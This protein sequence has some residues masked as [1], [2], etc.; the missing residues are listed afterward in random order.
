[1]LLKQL[2][3]TTIS[4]SLLSSSA[5]SFAKS[6][7]QP[8]IVDYTTRHHPVIA[9]D[10]MVSSQN[11]L[12]TEIGAQILRDGGNAIDASVAVG[13][14]LA[15]TL[16]RAGNLGGGGFMLVHIAE[17][18]KTIALDYRE[19][20]P[21]AAHPDMFFELDKNGN[22]VK[23]SRQDYHFNHRSSAV[24]GTVAGFE[25]VLKKYGTMSW[26]QV[27]APAIKLAREG[28]VVTDDL[29]SILR[30]KHKVL[31]QHPS[32]KKIFIKPDGSGY[33]AGD[34]L[35]QKDLAWSLQQLAK[36]GAKAFYQGEIG[37][38][39][40]ADMAANNGLITMEDLANYQVAIRKPVTGTFGDATINAM[41]APSSGGT[42]VV[43]ML[44]ILENFDLKAMGQNSAASYH[45][46]T[47]AMKLAYADRSKYLGDPDYVDIPT[48][49]LTS[50][51]YAADLAKTISLTKSR[52][53]KDIAPGNLAPY[54][55]DETTHY[56]VMDKHG[57][58]VSNTYTLMF[59]FGSGVV[60]EG[61]GI[62]MNNNLGNFTL[63][64]DIPDAFGLMGSADNLIRAGRRPVSSM[65]PTIVI[66]NN[67]PMLLTGSP[68]GSKIISTVMQQILNVLAFDMNL[69]D[70]TDAPRVHHQWSPDVLNLEPGISPDSIR[71]L[72]QMGHKTKTSKT[73]GSLQSIMYK[74]G[75]FFGYSDTRRPNALTIGLN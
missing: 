13:L 22:K 15:V 41:P 29:A 52:P 68:G 8:A 48:E 59:S 73:M 61:T 58:A 65:T 18:N 54:E 37:K 19:T 66:R 49:I 31:S 46:I 27:T 21:R 9:R 64:P 14:A 75:L 23:V 47:E 53:A 38:R 2:V 42:H 30:T 6:E 60:A 72:E 40:A 50:K 10:G 43:Q 16:P 67:K 62:I 63:S 74:D 33:K 12:A 51:T 71:L 4:L 39:L 25:W 5:L 45:V 56:S 1:M 35:K 70:A 57:N 26:Q 44:N 11:Y 34:V 24:P 69:A 28:F 7:H 20:A 55:S 36:E 32:S 3:T 17:E